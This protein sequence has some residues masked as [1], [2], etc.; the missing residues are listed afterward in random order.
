MDIKNSVTNLLRA[1]TQKLDP[2]LYHI[3]ETLKDEHQ[4]NRHLNISL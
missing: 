2:P 3:L 4:P 1:A